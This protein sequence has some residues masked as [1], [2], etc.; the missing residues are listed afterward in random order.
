MPFK[1]RVIKLFGCQTYLERHCHVDEFWLAFAPV[2]ER[3]HLNPAGGSIFAFT[4]P[5][6]R[7]P[8]LEK[9]T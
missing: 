8:M 6:L 5:I 4:V 9:E 2:W 1:E 3:K 7:I